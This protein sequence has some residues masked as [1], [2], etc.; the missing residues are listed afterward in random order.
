[1][2]TIDSFR[3]WLPWPVYDF[4][5]GPEDG[6]KLAVRLVETERGMIAPPVWEVSSFPGVEFNVPMPK[7]VMDWYVTV[8]RYRF[9]PNRSANDGHYE[10]IEP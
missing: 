2:T 9:I 1:V 5:G 4:I 7:E 6:K 3:A 8:S 10:W